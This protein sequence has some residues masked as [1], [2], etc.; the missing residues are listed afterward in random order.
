MKIDKET[1]IRKVAHKA[2]FTQGDV[3]IILDTMIE[4]I[5]E[6]ISTKTPMIIR[7]F[8]SLYYQE[9]APRRGSTLVGGEELPPATRIVM[10]LAKNLRQILKNNKGE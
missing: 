3:R 8:F 7:G 4:V 10:R 5:E 9:L 1:F 6:S 2:R